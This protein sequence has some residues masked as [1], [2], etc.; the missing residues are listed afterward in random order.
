LSDDI[1]RVAQSFKEQTKNLSQEDAQAHFDIQR[2]HYDHEYN[3][4]L[5]HYQKDG[6]YLCGKPISTISKKTPCLHWLL[7]RCKFK[8]KDFHT[9][10]DKFDF[11][12]VS[13]YLRWVSSAE[14]GCKNIN[15]LKEE[16]SDRKLFETTI[17]WKNKSGH[18]IVL[19]MTLKDM[20]V[21][22]QII[23]I[24]TFKCES[25][26]INLL[27]LVIFISLFQKMTS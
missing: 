23:P 16:S 7:R 2:E 24:G 6:C 15:N 13:A 10:Y 26:D 11:Y 5:E 4:F 20:T 12:N 9:V 1:Q 22:K 14:D 18:W 8:K 17:K 21:Q 25:M 19:T 27:T 3:N